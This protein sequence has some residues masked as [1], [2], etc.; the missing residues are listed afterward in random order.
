M[1]SIGGRLRTRSFVG[2]GLRDEYMERVH[3]YGFSRE[4]GCR[5]SGERGLRVEG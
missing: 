1:G 4:E 2:I 3:N 5:L